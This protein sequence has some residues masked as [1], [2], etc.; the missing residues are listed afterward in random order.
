MRVK[1][2]KLIHQDHYSIAKAAKE[3]KIPYDN[4]KAINR[5][6]VREQRI[7]KIDYRERYQTRRNRQ[8]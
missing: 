6:Y 3:T 5:T 4:A 8:N 7:S 2:V 1:L